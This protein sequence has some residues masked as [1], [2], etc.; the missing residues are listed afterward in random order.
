MDDNSTLKPFEQHIVQTL[1]LA[2]ERGYN[3]TVAQLA[4]KLI[5]GSISINELRRILPTL[6]ALEME[7][8]IV[9]TKE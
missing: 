2:E 1:Q 9:A 5:G 3:L 8:D 7:S 6:N 4:S